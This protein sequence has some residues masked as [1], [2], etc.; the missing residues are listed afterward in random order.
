MVDRAGVF[1][2][3]PDACDVKD[4]QILSSNSCSLQLFEEVESF[5]LVKPELV[6]EMSLHETYLKTIKLFLLSLKQKI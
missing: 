1:H 6:S 3:G 5:R 4:Y 2:C